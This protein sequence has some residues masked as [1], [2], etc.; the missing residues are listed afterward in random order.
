[1]EIEQIRKL[2]V[3]GNAF[4]IINYD[5]SIT[6]VPITEYTLSEIR[7]YL[8][9]VLAKKMVDYFQLR[10]AIYNNFKANLIKHILSSA[11]ILSLGFANLATP[12]FTL[13]LAIYICIALRDTYNSRILN[14]QYMYGAEDLGLS[15]ENAKNILGN[16][17]QIEESLS[18]IKTTEEAEKLLIELKQIKEELDEA[19]SN[20]KKIT[21]NKG[22]KK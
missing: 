12:V 10:T 7:N 4:K 17:N 22:G 2:E 9:N 15:Y 20:D 13:I 3:N 8:T 14:G 6:I 5:D 18:L 19:H 1:M 11:V 16:L 21:L